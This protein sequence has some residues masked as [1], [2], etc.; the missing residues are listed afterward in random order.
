MKGGV[1]N[2]FNSE[3]E[4]KIRLSIIYLILILELILAVSS[5]FN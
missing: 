5:F 4:P 3:R 2:M 1:L